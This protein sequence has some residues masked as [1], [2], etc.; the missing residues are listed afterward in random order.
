MKRFLTALAITASLAVASSA[1]ADETLNIGDPAP[2]LTVSG[3]VKGEKIES[4]RPDETYVVEFWAT[5]CGPCRASIPHL[6]ELAHEFKDKGVHFIG[7]DVWEN[8]TKLV[9]P[10][11]SEMGDK[12]DYAVALDSGAEGATRDGAMAKAWM[13]AAEEDGIPTAFVVRN[14]KIA[15]IGHPMDLEQPLSKIVGG[16]WD[17][18]EAAAKRLAD[19]ALERKLN[20]VYEKVRTP[21]SAKDYKATLAAIE[22]VAADDPEVAKRFDSIKFAS[23]CNGGEVERGLELGT[24]LLETNMDNAAALNNYFWDVID[25]D[26]KGEVDPRVAKLAL[27]AARRAVELKEEEAGYLDTLAAA[28]FRTGDAAAAVAT[29]EKAIAVLKNK[30]KELTDADLGQYKDHLELYRKKAA[31][32]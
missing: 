20:A 26:L 10:F 17:L 3:W 31:E 11:V 19:K 14:G 18:A 1:G 15:W 21:Y 28:L 24:N 2:P 22:Q 32:N 16:Q 8:D 7:V 27:K 25:P 13:A 4:L 9:Q 5:W 12:M 29:Q 30:H 6:T 23:L